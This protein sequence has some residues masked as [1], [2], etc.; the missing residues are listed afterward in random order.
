LYKADLSAADLSGAEMKKAKVDEA[1]F[2][3]AIGVSE[4]ILQG[5][6]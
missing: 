4:E 2:G 5:K 1:L 3:G 6:N